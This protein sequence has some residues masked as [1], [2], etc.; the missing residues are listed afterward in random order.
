MKKAIKLVF[1][2]WG[3]TLLCM[4]V[5]R[6]LIAAFVNE[7]PEEIRTV[8]HLVIDLIL[9]IIIFS[10]VSVINE[11]RNNN[12]ISVK[13]NDNYSF[14]KD[15]KDYLLNDGKYLICIYT[16]LAVINE[17]QF[18]ICSAINASR[19]PVSTILVPILPISFI[20]FDLYHLYVIPAIINIIILIASHSLMISFYHMLY[21]L[22][23]Q[24]KNNK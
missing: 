13:V 8:I 24:K 4:L 10:I 12:S 14:K 16:V 22:V 19:L 2:A 3:F 15:V 7:A 5:F 23:K 6:V 21:P 20:F 1:K 9:Y 17:I 11:K 18:A